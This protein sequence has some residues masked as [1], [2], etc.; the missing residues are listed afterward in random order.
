M[1]GMLKIIGSF[2]G[3]FWFGTFKH[4]WSI[5]LMAWVGCIGLDKKTFFNFFFIYNALN[6][7]NDI[8]RTLETKPMLVVVHVT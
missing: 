5:H 1:V 2:F 6:L 4:S 7:C 8:L 3:E